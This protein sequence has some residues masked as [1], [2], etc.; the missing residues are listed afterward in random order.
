MTAVQE[1]VG[2][3][4]GSRGGHASWED[5]PGP[6]QVANR[7]ARTLL[8][9]DLPIAA[10]PLTTNLVHWLYGTALG[11]PYVLVQR[12]LAPPGLAG[13][14]AFGLGVWAWSYVQLVPLGIYEPPWRYSPKQLAPDVGYHLVYGLGVAS[15]ADALERL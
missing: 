15:A 6:A 10:I 4:R 8:G 11:V 7:A 13:G 12:R 1:A 5:A 9:R 2:G 14:A 3:L